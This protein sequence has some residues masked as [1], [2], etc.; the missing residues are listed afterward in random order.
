MI[1]DSLGYT[2]KLTFNTKYPDG[3]TMKKLDDTL[4]RKEF[5]NLSFV[6]ID[7]GIKNTIKYY[8]KILK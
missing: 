4:F 6:K 3:A 5:P 1:K 8:Q 2:G 7:E